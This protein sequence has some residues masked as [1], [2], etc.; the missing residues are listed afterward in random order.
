MLNLYS[1]LN[2]AK[3]YDTDFVK[4]L[5]D[6]MANSYQRMNTITSFG[7]S[8]RWRKQFLGVLPKSNEQVYVLDLMTG[9]GEMWSNIQQHF[10]KARIAALDFSEGML[11]K[12]AQKNEVAHHNEIDL[13]CQD[14]LE[15]DLPSNHFD[16]VVCAFGLKTFDESQLVILATQT[17]R[18]LKYGGHFSF[19]EVSQPPNFILKKCYIFYLKNV[20]PI[21]GKLLCNNASEYKMLWYYT[22]HFEN[23]KKASDIF[24]NA[25][26][27]LQYKSYFYG[28][29]TGF[30]GC[31]LA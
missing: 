28:C 18:I 23:A 11:R 4:K 3:K 24:K 12:A 13:I 27:N 20:I 26:L 22:N 7:F 6:A 25:G 15:N 14:V 10:P 16:I 30:Y 21:L 8:V 1:S 29:A 9:M 19:I 17:A 2:Q 5:F 31:K